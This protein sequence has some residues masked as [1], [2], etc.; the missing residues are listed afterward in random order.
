MPLYRRL[1]KRGF[2]SLARRYVEVVRLADLQRLGVDEIDLAVLKQ[3][4]S[5]RRWRW[6]HAS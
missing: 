5:S 6:T 3:R 4:A 1:P 2:T